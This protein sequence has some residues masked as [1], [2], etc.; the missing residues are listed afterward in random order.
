MKKKHSKKYISCKSLSKEIFMN[1]R[2]DDF[3]FILNLLFLY[4]NTSHIEEKVFNNKRFSNYIFRWNFNS[5]FNI[6]DNNYFEDEAK[7]L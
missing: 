7:N 5:S 3:A 4:E 1:Q 6:I 2:K